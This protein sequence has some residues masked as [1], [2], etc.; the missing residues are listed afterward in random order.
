M[1]VPQNFALFKKFPQS[2]YCKQK[3]II[4]NNMTAL[5]LATKSHISFF[6][7]RFAGARYG[8][9]GAVAR[10]DETVRERVLRAVWR[11]AAVLLCLYVVSVNGVVREGGNIGVLERAIRSESVAVLDAETALVAQA[12]AEQLKK[13]NIVRMMEDIGRI[14]YVRLGSPSLAEAPHALP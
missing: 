4:A 3:V 10:F 6:G 1:R 13:N 9:F 2:D 14:D 7:S 11:M 12:S 5:L 8:V